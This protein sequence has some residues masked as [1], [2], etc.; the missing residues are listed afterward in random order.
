MIN[1]IAKVA[2]AILSPIEKA[3]FLGAVGYSITRDPDLPEELGAP[4]YL[5]EDLD[6]G[7]SEVY[8]VRFEEGSLLS[9]S[10]RLTGEDIDDFWA[11]ENLDVSPSTQVIDDPIEVSSAEEDFN[12]SPSIQAR[13]DPIE[14]SSVEEDLNVSP[15]IQVRDEPIEDFM[16]EEDFEVSPSAQARGH[17]IEK[18]WAVA[19][20]ET[21]PE[22][23]QFAYGYDPDEKLSFYELTKDVE[24][25]IGSLTTDQASVA[26]G[27]AFGERGMIP[28]EIRQDF[29]SSGQAHLLAISGLHI[30][31]SY[32]LGSKLAKTAFRLLPKIF[33]E[34]AST[35][36]GLGVAGAYT[37]LSGSNIPAMRASSMLVMGA[38]LPGSTMRNLTITAS[39]MLAMDPDLIFDPTF[40]L[41]F[42]AT[43][44]LILSA[45]RGKRTGFGLV[46]EVF[47][48]FKGIF[49]A[50]V[51]AT[52]V[53]API[54]AYHY[55]VINPYGIV[56][57]LAAIPITTYMV[58]PTLAASVAELSTLGSSYSFPL[59]RE[60]I[61]LLMWTAKT[62]GD[63]PGADIH[64]GKGFGF[65]GRQQM[66]SDYWQGVR[67]KMRTSA[68]SLMGKEQQEVDYLS[69]LRKLNK[70]FDDDEM[71]LAKYIVQTRTLKDTFDTWDK[72]NKRWSEAFAQIGY[73]TSMALEELTFQAITKGEALDL[74]YENTARSVVR[75]AVI[76]PITSLLLQIGKGFLMS[77]F[78]VPDMRAI[79][80]ISAPTLQYDFGD[81]L[82][83]P[84]LDG[85]R[86]EGGPVDTGRTYVVGEQGK[87]LFVPE[88]SKP[89]VAIS[90][91]NNI[92][93]EGADVE[94]VNVAI[95]QMTKKIESTLL[96]A[97]S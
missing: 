64:V 87:E 88:D 8:E 16:V 53:T 25:P 58:I 36:V 10:V 43:A 96:S 60:P 65:G 30:G 92:V 62:F 39:A 20:G 1:L 26:L 84:W 29:R 11:D 86:A 74:I 56:S 55:G 49:K 7:S 19:T 77:Y 94:G 15:S 38:M 45:G 28:P 90:T 89:R 5:K 50:S 22:H 59:M 37:W 32:L 57:N 54:V 76:D 33:S 68:Y 3:V 46:G 67:A 48:S 23:V 14:V 63:L 69:S 34:P 79:P 72:K 73:G 97:L 2:S 78:S 47:G 31:I 6:V 91:R 95:A 42:G 9:P 13:D 44:G 40:Q 12:V 21:I 82:G 52:G 93:V 17:F 41:S 83:F 51:V 75:A 81:K 18:F 27:L 70:K 35:A 24:G 61:A 85:S 4:D 66:R 71:S 80:E